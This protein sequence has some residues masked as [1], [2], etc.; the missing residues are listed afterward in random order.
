MF[1]TPNFLM[2][3]WNCFFLLTSTVDFLICSFLSRHV[4]I[5][6]YC[7]KLNEMIKRCQTFERQTFHISREY[8]IFFFLGVFCDS[9]TS[10]NLLS[11]DWTNDWCQQSLTTLIDFRFHERIYLSRCALMNIRTR[12]V[13]CLPVNFTVHILKFWRL[14][15]L[16]VRLKFIERANLEGAGLVPCHSC[17]CHNVTSDCF[18]RRTADRTQPFYFLLGHWSSFAVFIR[19]DIFT[20]WET[21]VLFHLSWS[22]LLFIV[23]QQSMYHVH[24]LQSFVTGCQPEGHTGSEGVRFSCWSDTWC[25]LE[26]S[27][28]QSPARVR[29]TG[30]SPS[31]KCP[32]TCSKTGSHVKALLWWRPP[33]KYWTN[34]SLYLSKNKTLADF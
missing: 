15:N 10:S 8:L 32:S 1:R 16:H 2:L 27:R 21:F 28:S 14:W 25:L 34:L 3:N 7:D 33:T 22:Q 29:R 13:C 4:K 24:R 5:W 31:Y 19:S 11:P 23:I 20:L 17:S 18:Y 12:P 6:I 26:G 9:D 30:P